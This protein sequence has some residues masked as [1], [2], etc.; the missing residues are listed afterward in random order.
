MIGEIEFEIDECEIKEIG[1]DPE[2]NREVQILM[3]ENQELKGENHELKGEIQGLNG[4]IER[5]RE[6][7]AK[8]LAN[9]ENK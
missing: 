4:E 1:I 8:V 2:E 5:L 7:I 3:Q 6:Q 9:K